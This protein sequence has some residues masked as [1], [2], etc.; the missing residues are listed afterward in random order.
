MPRKKE[1][2]TLSVPV[3]TKAALDAIARRLKIFWG[4][5]PSPSGLVGA[6]ALGELEVAQ[7]F[8]LSSSQMK[9]LRQAIRDLVDADHLEE[10]KSVITLLIEKGNLEA[11][12]RQD[13]M[14]QVSQPMEGWRIQ[15]DQ[16]I[17]Q[18]QP[19][20]LLYQNSQGQ[21][22]EY[23][24][25]YAEVMFYEKRYYLQIWCDETEDSQD[26]PELQ[27]NRCFRLDRI[28]SIFPISGEWRGRFDTIDIQLHLL[29]WL[30]RAYEPKPDDIADELIGEVRQ[31][32]RRV[33]NP[34][35]LIR[36]VFR[37]GEDCV[38]VSPESVRDRFKQKLRSLCEY[39]EL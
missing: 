38:I 19:F 29:G 17:E 12:M 31:V 15:V 22:L 10:A 25:R 9:V 1:T 5:N 23:T 34:F 4:S 16:L 30:V 7:P 13:L 11:P 3:G 6:I 36:E 27:H 37:Y 20:H 14:Q 28:Q 2:L 8:A 18:Q 26:L 32:I 21:V 39:Y 35:W 33:V 24:V